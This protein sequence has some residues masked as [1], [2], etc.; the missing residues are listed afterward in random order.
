VVIPVHAEADRAWRLH[1]WDRFMVPKPFARVRMAYGTPFRVERGPAGEADA[2]QR[3][4]AGMD[5]VVDLAQWPAR[6]ATATG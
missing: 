3:V 6:A 5:E 4:K 2:M 1:S